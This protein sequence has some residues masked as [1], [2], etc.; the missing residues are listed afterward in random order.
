M[1]YFTELS[2]LFEDVVNWA[3]LRHEQRADAA[4]IL[5]NLKKSL[6]KAKRDLTNA[7]PAAEI[8]RSEPNTLA[9][10]RAARPKGPR[11][12]CDAMPKDRMQS[13]MRGAW[14][15]R[16][17]GCTLGAPVESWQV[18][19]MEDLARVGKQAFPPT[20]YWAI[21][22]NP[23]RVHYNECTFREYLKGNLRAVPVDDDLAYTLLG[24]L[25]LE[26]FGPKF[27]TKDV[28]VAWLDHVPMAYTAEEVALNNL[29]R[30]VPAAKAAEI[31]NPYQEWIG[32]DI[33]SDPWGYAAPGWPER[34]AEYAYRDA[35]LSHRYNGI[36][37]EMFFSAAI[38]AAF[39]VDSP[40]EAL[41]IGLTEIPKDCRL[42]RD[43]Q[44]AFKRAPGI[45]DWRDARKVVDA[46]FKGMHHVHTNN[47]ACLTV[48]GLQLGQ[49][50]FT[51]TIG[52]VVAMGLDNDCTAATAGSI[53]GAVYGIE[54]IPEHWWKPFRNEV[55]SY[56]RGH[57]KFATSD[58]VK[59]FLAV[60]RRTWDEG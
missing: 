20:D 38:A 25:I 19:A 7:K 45:R 4:S 10:I 23:S 2:A 55:R 6:E 57:K 33:R 31:G 24:L 60:A 35:Y 29:K 3:D 32:A 48:F 37:G 28:G 53:F 49:D 17:A 5:A 59:R 58:V 21:H 12:L 46:R 22:P 11:R 13:R 18:D 56:L 16:A 14:L 44:W 15:R 30:G 9:D 8:V 50:D 41:R 42:A 54:G 43:L 26:R 47:N 39:V 40:M 34:A 51:K 1:P 52:G 36:Y 27:S